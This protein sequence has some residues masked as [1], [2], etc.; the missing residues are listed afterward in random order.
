MSPDVYVRGGGTGYRGPVLRGTAQ[1]PSPGGTGA[2]VP[3]PPQREGPRRRFPRDWACSAEHRYR[4]R[5]VYG[6]AVALGPSLLPSA[7][8][9]APAAP[10]DDERA[11]SGPQGQSHRR[12]APVFSEGGRPARPPRLPPHR[13]QRLPGAADGHRGV[14]D[15]QD[16]RGGGPLGGEDLPDQPVG[17]CR[18]GAL[19]VH[20]LHLLPRSTSHRHRLRCQRRG[21]PGAHAKDL[22]TPAQY[23]LMEKDAL[24]VA[25]EMQA[26]YWAVSSLTG[27][28]VRDFFFRV[29]AL[30]FESSVLAELE[31]SSA[32]K[33]GDTGSAAT[34]ATCTCRRPARKSAASEGAATGPRCAHTSGPKRGGPGQ[35]RGAVPA[36][37]RPPRPAACPGTHSQGGQEHPC[38]SLSYANLGTACRGRCPRA[39]ICLNKTFFMLFKEGVGWGL[40]LTGVPT[41][42]GCSPQAHGQVGG[43]MEP[44]EDGCH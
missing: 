39:P 13:S 10:R 22:S 34:R 36:A 43:W 7:T 20:R 40:G 23:S 14:Q 35:P 17:H 3:P 8:Q 41:A 2:P 12:P 5:E 18:P 37:P 9:L 27:E 30:T 42:P 4:S 15:L 31:R 16:H 28:N 29:A 25:Q 26:E 33:I 6:L 21:V 11:G 1:Q 32:R 24:K 19:Q 38:G 44:G